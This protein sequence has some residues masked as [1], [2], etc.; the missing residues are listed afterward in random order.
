M[1]VMPYS[2][3]I[4]PVLRTLTEYCEQKKQRGD[5]LLDLR[6]G[7]KLPK[8]L[9]S[10]GVPDDVADHFATD[11]LG[12]EGSPPKRSKTAWNAGA[13]K[14]TGWWSAWSGDAEGVLRE[15]MIRAIEV[16]LG[17]LHG[18][19]PAA[20]TRQWH[21]TF[22]W[23]CGAPTLQGWVSWWDYSAKNGNGNGAHGGGDGVVNVILSTPGNGKPLCAT[24]YRSDDED[25]DG[26][27]VNPT[28]AIGENGMWVIAEQKTEARAPG[29]WTFVD[30]GHG[31][32]PDPWPSFFRTS[33]DVVTVAPAEEAGRHY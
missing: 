32:I 4:G 33:G 10:I 5:L 16:S 25:P 2:V 15:T 31:N 24:P 26:Y 9:K 12:Y 20:S 22:L 14:T 28:D 1:A 13:P 23:T 11:W 21:L 30:L 17:L 18:A 29:S 6:K 27:A 8:L 19:D 3:E 7:E